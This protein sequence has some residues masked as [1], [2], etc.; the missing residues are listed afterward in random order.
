M[1]WHPIGSAIHLIFARCSNPPFWKV[2]YVINCNDNYSCRDRCSIVDDIFVYTP[3]PLSLL[4][5]I[6]GASQFLNIP[7]TIASMGKACGTQF[8]LHERKKKKEMNDILNL[9]VGLYQ[10][11]E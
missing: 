10:L 2:L 8:V 7:A 11:T 5:H 3:M 6:V 1:W 9:K 4:S